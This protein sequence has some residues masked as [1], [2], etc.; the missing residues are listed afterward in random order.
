[1]DRITELLARMSELS[2]GELSELE[3]LVLSEFEALEKADVTSETVE[4]MSQLG[5]A[6]EGLQTEKQRRVEQAAELSRRKDDAAA[7][8]RAL[9]EPQ[10]SLADE[11]EENAEVEGAEKREPA[12]AEASNAAPAETTMSTNEPAPAAE[13][14]APAAV[15]APAEAPAAEPVVSAGGAYGEMPKDAS[16]EAGKAGQSTVPT[17]HSETAEAEKKA[18]QSEE[19]SVTASSGNNAPE[20]E[21]TVD[22]EQATEPVTASSGYIGGEL[23]EHDPSFQPPA[24]RRPRPRAEATVAITAGA[25]IPGVSAGSPLNDMNAVAHAFTQ[26]LRTMS[27]THGGDGEQHVVATLE[28][29]FPEA[30]RLT[31]SDANLNWEKINEVVS[32]Q[33]ITAAGGICMPLDVRYDLFG[34]GALG[35]PVKDSLPS[36]NA[37]RGGIRFMQPPTLADV[38]GA[39]SLWTLQDD[40]DAATPGLPDPVK[41]CIRINCGPEVQAFVD[42]IV[43]CLTFGNM[44]SRAWPELV[45][46]HNELALIQQARFAETRLLTKIGLLSTAVTAARQLG[47]AVDHFVAIDRAVTTFRNRHRMVDNTPLRYMAPTWLR[48]ML[49]SDIAKRMPG[50]GLTDT[51]AVADNVIDGFFRSRG[52]NVTWFIDGEAGQMFG[53]QTPGALMDYPDN[54][55]WYLFP[56]G[57]F[58]F[59]DG[60]TL[61]LGLVRDS[62]LNGTNDYKVFVETFEGVAKVGLE[63]L[64]VTQRL[65]A[66]GQVAGTVD[67]GAGIV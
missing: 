25:D 38:N 63:S 33:A 26:R 58:L 64:R 7:R 20:G 5:D 21:D 42:A 35:R 59:L 11:V 9:S 36:F 66:T 13:P 41:P 65:E 54:V 28:A 62:T 56:E 14:A 4:K 1:M 16:A 2:D 30:R 17:L 34:L 22:K 6:A 46:R 24:D 29:N 39:V 50:D 23:A 52:V 8:I 48:S 32:P 49:R 15:E 45:A 37:T 3:G 55:I 51:L 43:L 67:T 12:L 53:E 61:D 10:E 31:S 18:E 19:K 44:G 47:A 27:R 40:I 60:G 57:T